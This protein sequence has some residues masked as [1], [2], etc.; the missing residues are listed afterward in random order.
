M[1]VVTAVQL[2]G[3]K[4]LPY[5]ICNGVHA[6]VGAVMF[7]VTVVEDALAAPALIET[8]PPVGAVVSRVM[9]SVVSVVAF[10]AAS[11]N[12]MYTVFVPSPVASVCAIDVLV[13]VQ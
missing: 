10:P 11:I 6:S 7:S 2:V 5:A 4:V 1:L 9:V 12:R 8:P 13:A 3:E